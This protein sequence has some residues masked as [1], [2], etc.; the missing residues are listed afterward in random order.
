MESFLIEPETGM[1]EPGPWKEGYID[2]I[3]QQYAAF[4]MKAWRNEALL[5]LPTERGM[6]KPETA[7]V[8]SRK[9]DAGGKADPEEALYGG[10]A[11]YAAADGKELGNHD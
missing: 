11:A 2:Y 10:L 3:R 7:T 8:M 6:L 9:A 4:E 1:P 5:R